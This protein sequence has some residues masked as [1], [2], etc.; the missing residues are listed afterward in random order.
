VTKA[1]LDL[2]DLN[3]GKVFVA[4]KLLRPSLND[5][6]RTRLLEEACLMAQFRHP[7]I[8]EV[9]GLIVDPQHTYIFTSFCESGD[10]LQLLRS[11][12]AAAL[13]I[14]RR[15]AACRDVARGMVSP[16]SVPH[17]FCSAV[18]QTLELALPAAFL[19]CG[20]SRTRNFSQIFLWCTATLPVATS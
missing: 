15:C 9:V 13:T 18:V 5:E 3:S 19:M 11:P 6:H 14:E 17:N 12:K 16:G 2:D 7:N 4:M 1:V 20:S 8:L 10:L